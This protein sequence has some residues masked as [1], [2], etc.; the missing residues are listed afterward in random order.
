MFLG[1]PR[2]WDKIAESM[3]TR[4]RTVGGFKGKFLSWARGIGLKA[5]IS[6]QSG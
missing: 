5:N 4:L 3:L 2:V 1:V 6:K